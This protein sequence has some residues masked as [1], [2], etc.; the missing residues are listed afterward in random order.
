MKHN[1]VIKE[2][3]IENY[4]L[5]RLSDRETDDFEEHLLYC[6]ECRNM[7]AE[8]K[9]IMALTQYMAIH[10][11]NEQNKEVVSQKKISFFKPWMRA[12]AVLLL[13]VCSAG[14]IW[15]LIQKPTESFVLNENKPDPVKHF[16]DSAT[17]DNTLPL[18]TLNRTAS[19]SKKELLSD[20][21]RE[22]DLYETAIKNNLRGENIDVISPAISSNIALGEKVIFT[23]KENNRK[24]LLSVIA[25]TGKFLFE[26]TV[27]TPFTLPL[28]LQRGLYY[29]EITENDEVAFVSKFY[30]K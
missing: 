27:K 19:T 22:V 23:L 9:E 28:K 14:I 30:I 26:D 7:L 17:F 6:K 5:H 16:H 25:N 15:Y 1:F 29:W 18:K 24:I 2:G 4:L 20:N 8:T 3:I 12:A 21:Y 10:S 13:T 11:S